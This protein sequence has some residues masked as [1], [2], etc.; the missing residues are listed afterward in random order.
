[1]EEP[2]VPVL[3]EE[4]LSL[5]LP[6]ELLPPELLD[7]LLEEEPPE[8]FDDELPPLE[9][10]P[11]ALLLEEPPALLVPEP[12]PPD[13]EVPPAPPSDDDEQPQTPQAR[14]PAS[15]RPLDRQFRFEDMLPPNGRYSLRDSCDSTLGSVQ[16]YRGRSPS[17]RERR[18]DKI[19]HIVFRA[20]NST[21]S[22]PKPQSTS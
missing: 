12:V 16:Q 6:P 5:E 3:L 7:E 15:S 1:L 22:P 11:P 2:P 10:E 13:P 17:L 9:E 21:K 4:E 8:A 20:A 14:R 18:I 19:T